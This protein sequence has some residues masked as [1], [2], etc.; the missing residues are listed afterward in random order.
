MSYP[1]PKKRLKNKE[2]VRE[3]VREVFKNA[4]NYLQI[5]GYGLSFLLP[6]ESGYGEESK[7]AALSINIDFPYR[8]IK[9]SIHPSSIESSLNAEIKSAWWQNFERSLIHEAIHVLLWHLVHVAQKRYTN[10][11][12][13]E[14]AEESAVDHLSFA[15]H[16]LISDL[17]EAR[18]K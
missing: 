7:D 8:Y 14:E 3:W 13:I 6:G 11:Q 4:C 17:R 10:M 12:E 2:E 9:L 5:D 15:I 16:M 18:K 1:Q